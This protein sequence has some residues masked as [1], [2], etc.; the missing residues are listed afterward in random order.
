MKVKHYTTFQAAKL[1]SVSPDAVLKWIK[2]GKIRAYRTPGGHYR[3]A[4][5]CIQALME[6]AHHSLQEK[7][8]TKD[9]DFQY[10]WEYNTDQT[11]C[12]KICRDCIVFRVRARRCYAMRELPAEFGFS[13][14]SCQASCTDCN[15]FLLARVSN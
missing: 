9:Q 11:E 5:S 2:S 10:C 14:S 4:E 3:I 8:H 6:N 12:N 13:I 1:L 7:N 15:Y